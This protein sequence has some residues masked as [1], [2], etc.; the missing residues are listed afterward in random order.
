M[1]KELKDVNANGKPEQTN[2]KLSTLRVSS[3]VVP[4]GGESCRLVIVI[5]PWVRTYDVYL[6]YGYATSIQR[7]CIATYRTELKVWL[8]MQATISAGMI[9]LRLT[10]GRSA[11]DYVNLLP[12]PEHA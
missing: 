1:G 12:A 11:W 9:I 7:T 4:P 2:I 10:E 5:P 6:R 8:P 3:Y